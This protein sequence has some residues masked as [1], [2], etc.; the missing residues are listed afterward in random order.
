MPLRIPSHWAVMFNIFVE[1]PADD[2]PTPAEV[3]AYLSD[4]ILSVEQVGP[5]GRIEYD[6]PTRWVIDLGWYP[7]GDPEGTYRLCL[8]RDG[9]DD[10]P[11]RFEHR[12]CHVVR[13]AFDTL[14]RMLAEG[15]R[16]DLIARVLADPRFPD[17]GRV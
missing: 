2:P 15:K 11:V 17:E 1:F 9:W 3:D 16:P 8:V 13:E 10:V 5:T 6:D 14:T 4:D 12:D 7:P